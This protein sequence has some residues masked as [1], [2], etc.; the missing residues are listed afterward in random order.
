MDTQAHR[1][2]FQLTVYETRVCEVAEDEE[3]NVAVLASQSCY[4]IPQQTDVYDTYLEDWD[5]NTFVG[6]YR[7][8]ANLCCKSGYVVDYQ[9]VF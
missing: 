7:K 1:H 4:V 2:P 6:F 5:H 8:G 9:V 3:P